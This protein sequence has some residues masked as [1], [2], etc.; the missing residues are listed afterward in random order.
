V[1]PK[2]HDFARVALGNYINLPFHG[3]ERPILEPSDLSAVAVDQWVEV[4][5][6]PEELNSPA[7]WRKR[8]SWLMIENPANRDVHAD[9]EF[10][11]STTL[12][13]CADYIIEGAMSGERPIARGHRSTV[14]FN[15]AKQLANC[16]LWSQM[17]TLEALRAVRDASD[18]ALGQPR[19]SDSELSRYVRNAYEKRY[20]STGCD[21]PVFA[22]YAHPDC[23][24]ANPRR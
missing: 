2:A 6:R 13:M 8:A 9:R 16:A 10:G 22:P 21:D 24:I 5:S 17:E 12:H 14:Y 3:D 19:K 1:F 20:T 18:D 11:T 23:R 15:L 4:A 7:D